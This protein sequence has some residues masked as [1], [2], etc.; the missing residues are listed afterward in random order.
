MPTTTYTGIGDQASYFVYYGV[1]AYSQAVALTGTQKAFNV[2]R[3]SDSHTCDILIA[4]TGDLG[5]TIN[6]STAADNGQTWT[7][8]GASTTLTV[9]TWYD[10]VN[11][12][13]CDATTLTGG[14]TLVSL[15]GLPAVYSGAGVNVTIQSGSSCLE[16][17]AQPYTISAVAE[18]N[19]NFTT[20]NDIAAGIFSGS[21]TAFGFFFSAGANTT[22][23]YAGS[24]GA[25]VTTADS[26]FHAMQAV[27]NGALSSI[28]IDG[29]TT[30]SLNP[31][32]SNLGSNFQIG[33]NGG[34]A[35]TVY[36]REVAMALGGQ[37]AATQA[38][39]CHNQFNYFG[40]T[41]SC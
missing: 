5:N 3:A 9:A 7:A 40:T 34:R 16:F 15:N 32:T 29:V 17:L 19:G 22:A 39:V 37:N 13:S 30:G 8:F 41:T 38:A 1:R 20:E 4:T 14:F 35:E 23:Q 21:S 12:G 26:V 27:F 33:S 2:S 28:N 24:V 10:Q 18:R 25:N 11:G 31:G 6:C 36:Y